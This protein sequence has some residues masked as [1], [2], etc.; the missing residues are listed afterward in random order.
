MWMFYFIDTSPMTTNTALNQF[1]LQNILLKN[2]QSSTNCS[3]PPPTSTIFS[4]KIINTNNNN[5]IGLNNINLPTTTNNLF[6]LL[7]K[8]QKQQNLLQPLPPPLPQN[9]ELELMTKILAQQQQQ[10][11]FATVVSSLNPILLPNSSNI[12]SKSIL[13]ISTK[14][15]NNQVLQNTQLLKTPPPPPIL[16]KVM[17]IINI[18][19]VSIFF[20]A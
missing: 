12:D 19:S 3:L 5:S 10:Q 7:N 9:L 15:A 13:K 16:K 17:H 4:K 18:Q 20:C 1:L 2:G 11:Q 6:D 14:I 8:Q